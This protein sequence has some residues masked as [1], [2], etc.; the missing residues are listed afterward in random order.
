MADWKKI[1]TIELKE[2][3]IDINK[4]PVYFSSPSEYIYINMNGDSYFII[5]NGKHLR[6]SDFKTKELSKARL[7]EVK[8]E[9]LKAID[10]SDIM[11]DLFEKVNKR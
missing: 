2:K 6:R 3:N 10:D 7:S 11:G 8:G 1:S 5:R 4:Y 9:V